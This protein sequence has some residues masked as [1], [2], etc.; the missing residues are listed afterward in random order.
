LERQGKSAESVRHWE[1]AVVAGEGLMSLMPEPDYTQMADC[2]SALA[3][4]VDRLDDP[5]RAR[6]LLESNLRM[7]DNLPARARTPAI[8]FALLR[9]REE[10]RLIHAEVAQRSS[11]RLEVSGEFNSFS[12]LLL[13]ESDPILV[14]ELALRVMEVRRSVPAAD[15]VD[16][17]EESEIALRLSG[18]L[19]TRAAQQR[20]LG[21][22]DKARQTADQ[23]HALARLLVARHPDQPAAHL[24]LSLSF[25]Q[26]AKNAWRTDDRAS[27]KR[28]RKLALDAASQALS[29]NPQ[30]A[31]A[32]D[33]VADLQRRLSDLRT[34]RGGRLAQ[35]RSN[36]PVT[37]AGP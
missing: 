31:R 11:P 20:R 28:N 24:A 22:L 29:L 19:C 18:S 7:L 13:A 21:R 6:A 35:Y 36:P 15:G 30:N 12:R 9:T 8:V 3:R 23:L 2:R 10:L 34:P 4:L 26:F 14:E 33:E 5:E 32:R 16:A 1:K 27:V 25:A 17:T 37:P